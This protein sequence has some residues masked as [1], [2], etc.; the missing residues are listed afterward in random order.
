MNPII[1]K[2]KNRNNY[3]FSAVNSVRQKD[4]RKKNLEYS[5]KDINYK[6]YPSGIP[7]FNIC[8]Y[9]FIRGLETAPIFSIESY[10]KM[11]VGTYLHKMYQTES[12][13]AEDLLW[14]FPDLSTFLRLHPNHMEINSKLVDN[15]PEVPVFDPDSGISGRADLVLNFDSPVV[16]DIKTTSLDLYRWNT[17]KSKL[18]GEPHRVQVSIY[19]YLMNKYKYYSKPIKKAGL[20]YVNL[21]IPSGDSGSELEVYFDYD[22]E[23]EFKTGLLI[24]HLGIERKRYIDNIESQCTYPLCKNHS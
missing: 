22:E 11:E 16:F 21:L 12:L 17:N 23:M 1:K 20:G 15:W 7:S 19:C 24:E 18:P 10:Y 2:L 4:L 5:W 6:I 9:E 8:P 3:F 13:K 14:E